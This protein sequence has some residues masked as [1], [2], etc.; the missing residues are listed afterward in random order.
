M[1]DALGFPTL[2]DAFLHDLAPGRVC[3][4][5]VEHWDTD[6]GRTFAKVAEAQ[7][8][9]ALT[10]ALA[11]G[12]VSPVMSTTS[13]GHATADPHA[14]DVT[15]VAE[16]HTQ[17]RQDTPEAD[18]GDETPA[19]PAFMKELAEAEGKTP[20]ATYTLDDGTVVNARSAA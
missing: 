4:V 17:K 2:A 10:A 1:S 19:D 9:P 11:S 13:T 14:V 5:I 12:T 6:D 8:H 15:A 20:P 16:A 7:F 18:G 3:R